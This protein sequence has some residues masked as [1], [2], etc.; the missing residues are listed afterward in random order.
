MHAMNSSSKK[1]LIKHEG[2]IAVAW[3]TTYQILVI[4]FVL[5][6]S[7]WRIKNY[8]IAFSI[9]AKLMQSESQSTYLIAYLYQSV[10]EKSCFQTDTLKL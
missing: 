10:G 5:F 6:N 1:K 9:C 8:G 3:C 7:L 2:F 4:Q